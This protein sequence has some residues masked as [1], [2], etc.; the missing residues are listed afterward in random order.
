MAALIGIVIVFLF[1]IFI[2]SLVLEGFVSALIFAISIVIA[3][4]TAYFVLKYLHSIKANT[5]PVLYIVSKVALGIS[6]FLY[7]FIF[8]DLLLSTLLFL[9]CV[10]C[11]LLPIVIHHRLKRK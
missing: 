5:N 7:I 3:A 10:T 11:S 1:L 2:L 4:V 9:A 6:V 8:E